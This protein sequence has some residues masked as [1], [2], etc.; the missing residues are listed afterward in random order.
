MLSKENGK[1]LQAACARIWEAKRCIARGHTR[2][3]SLNCREA[4][5]RLVYVGSRAEVDSGEVA[6][7]IRELGARQDQEDL[8][9]FKRAIVTKLGV[10]GAVAPDL[11]KMFEDRI[12]EAEDVEELVDITF[13]MGFQLSARSKDQIRE[14]G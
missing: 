10:V 11:T 3:A 9:W 4:D 8:W 12:A 7:Y 2:S 1:V 13:D 6:E 14:G 5:E